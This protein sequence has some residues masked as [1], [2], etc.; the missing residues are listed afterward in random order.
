MHPLK[1]SAQFAAFVWFT[2]QKHASSAS[3]S[4][5]ANQHWQE[6]LPSAHEGL[7]LL[8]MKI[9]EPTGRQKPA[10]CAAKR[11]AHASAG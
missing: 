6:F 8:L 5:F 10:R 1:T 9:A 4:R 2:N 3:A 11:R 7:G